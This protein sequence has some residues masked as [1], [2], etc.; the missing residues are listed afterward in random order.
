MLPSH[1][2][3]IEFNIIPP[4]TPGLPG[5]LFLSGFLTKTQ[6][7]CPFSLVRATCPAYLILL[8]LITPITFDEQY[9]S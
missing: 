3:K 8:D 1:F 7:A 2:L 5:Y 6:Y 9:I 4:S